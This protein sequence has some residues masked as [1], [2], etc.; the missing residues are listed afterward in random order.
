MK[1][2]HQEL[3]IIYHKYKAIKSCLTEKGKRLWAA[4]E[5]LP[6]GHGGILLVNKATRISTNTIRRGIKEIKFSKELDEEMESR[7]RKKGGGRK[8]I[9]KNQNNVIKDLEEL[10]EPTSRGDPESHLKWTCKSTRNLAK[11]L[12][13]KGYK[14]SHTTVASLLHDLNYSLQANKKTLEGSSH[15]DRDA[16][17]QYINTSITIMQNMDQPT[18]SV[19]T[20]K[21]ENIGN[22]KNNGKEFCKKKDPIKVNGHDF[23]D[24]RL[25]KVVPYGVYDIGKN[26][27][28]VSVGISSD[29][30]EFAVNSIRAWWYKMGIFTYSK[31]KELL[32]TADCGGSNGYRVHLWKYELQCFSNETGLKIHVRHFP[33][34]TSKWNKIE[35]RLFSYI[36]KNW[37]G[38]PLL[39]RE[40][41]VNLIGNTK[42]NKGLEVKAI[43]D[44]NR[45]MKG[46]KISKKEFDSIQI[47]KDEFHPEWNYSILPNNP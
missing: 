42:T 37:R 47:K 41:V 24:I 23:P 12:N 26:K 15:N 29:T 7:I 33:P 9:L 22:Y 20:K 35:H 16:Q 25:G 13:Q 1:F 31:S 17:F 14:I 39:T 2:E 18:I 21:K 19:D 38:K 11:A 3:Q 8:K 36:S 43:L 27:G 46:K 30:A 40:I 4:A 6:Y 32:I 5:A 45:Y 10:V 44:E 28:W 34:G